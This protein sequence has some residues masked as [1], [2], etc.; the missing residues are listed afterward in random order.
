MSS[1]PKPPKPA[2][3]PGPKPAPGPAPEPTPGLRAEPLYPER[4]IRRAEEALRAGDL[5]GARAEVHKGRTHFPTHPF[6]NQLE[7][8]LKEEDPKVILAGAG[9]ERPWHLARIPRKAH[10]YWGNDRTSFLRYLSI[11]SFRR[12]NPD[13]EVNLYVPSSVHQG[14]S[15]W[16]DGEAY[17]GTSYHGRDYSALLYQLPG[18]RIREVDFS[19][20]PAIEAAPETYKSDFFRWHILTGEGGAYCDTD[21]LFCRPLR[22]APFNV[23][24]HRDLQAGVCIHEG[25]HI[26]GFYFSAP[27]TPLFERV[28]REAIAAFDASD[29]Q[30]IG[31][32][33]L[34]RLY[35][36]V[37][38]IRKAHP[39]MA[40]QSL[41]MEL[42]YPFDWRE[43]HR[44]HEPGDPAALPKGCI[45]IHWYAGST[46]TQKFNNLIDHATCGQ[47]GSLLD[48]LAASLVP[49]LD[50]K[51]EGG[52]GSASPKGPRFSV[53]VP[54]YNQAHFL[55]ATLDSL[56]GQTYGAWEALVVNDGST[57]G[58]R[59]VLEA[60]AAKDPRIRAFH[61]A[62]GGVGSALNA[63]LAQATGDWVGWLS[64]D[65]LYEPGALEAFA[66]AITELPKAR[67]FYSNFSQLFDETGEKRPMPERRQ[68][69]LPTFE[70][71]TL[72][73]LEANYVN[74]ITVCIQRS[75]LQESGG[76]RPE[77][78]YAQDL[79]LWLRLSVRTRFH[80]L[81]H[82]TA[83]T[84]VHGAQ[85]TQTFPMAGFFDSA[86][87]AH[88]FLN[89]HRFEAIF[90]WADLRSQAEIISVLNGAFKVACNLNAF[91]YHG[92]GP[93][94]VLL[95]RLDE[96]L[97]EKCPGEYREIIVAAL[98]RG[99]TTSPEL[100][101]FLR[102]RGARLGSAPRP[103]FHPK[104][105][106]AL[107]EEVLKRLEGSGEAQVS[108]E[109]R[110]YLVK[111][112]GRDLGGSQP[113]APAPSAPAARIVIVR[114]PGYA[115]ADA[116][117]EVAET[118]EAGLRALG[119]PVARVEN[120]VA[121]GAFNILLGWH[122]LAEEA[123]AALPEGTVLY[124]LEQM[125]ERNRE[126]R[127]RI[128]RLGRRHTVWD[129]SPRNAE[130]LREAGLAQEPG[131]LPIGYAPLLTRIPEAPREDIDV[132]FYGSINPRRLQILQDLQTA[133]LKVHQAFGVYGS[134]RDALI[135]RA[136]VVLNLHYYDSS[137]FELVR[138]SYLLANRKAVVAECHTATEVEAF[139]REGL[140]LAPY[141]GLVQACL[142][143]IADEPARRA[144]AQRGYERMADR[145]ITPLLRPLLPPELRPSRPAPEVSVILPTRD[146][147]EFLDRALQSLQAQTYRD[148]EVIVVK[149]GGADPGEVV[150]RHRARGLDITLLEHPRS[151]G[152]AA[153]RN[154]GIR[155]ARGRWIAYLDDDDL[156]YPDHLKVLVATLER[157]GAQ[158]A[159]TDSMRAVEELRDGAW[160]VLSR[161]LAMSNAF[162]RE[163][164]LRDNLTPVN[165]VLHA[166]ACWEA[167]G[168]H[169]ETLPV[170]EDWEF[171][172]RLSRRWDFVHVPQATAEVRWRSSGANITFEKRDLFPQCRARIAAKVARLLAEEAARR[173]DP[174]R[175]A[176]LF[177]PD[178]AGAGWVEVLLA[179]MEAFAPGDPVILVLPMDPGREGQI[180][181]EEA[182]VR[183]LD[184]VRRTG[185]EAFP[186]VALVDRPEELIEILREREVAQWVPVAGQEGGWA[187]EGPRGRALEAARRRLRGGARPEAP[188]FDPG[189]PA[190]SVIIPTRDRPDPL[191][192]ALRSIQEQTF[193]DVEVIVVNDG[194]SPVEA[195]VR[196]FQEA[197][198]AASAL[199][200]PFQKGQAAARNSG[201]ARAKGR[202][203]AY[204][205]DDDRFE[206][207][208]LES[209]V[210]ALRG[211]G[212][213]VAYSDVL[214]VDEDARG[215]T[216][217]QEAA[218][219]LDFDRERLLRENLAPLDAVLHA[220]AC[221]EAVGPMDEEL[222]L[223]E[224]W[225]FLI[226]LSRAWDFVHVPKAT[227]Q[228]RWRADGSNASLRR[229]P[230]L[231][232]CRARI[233]QKVEEGMASTGA[234]ISGGS[235]SW[236]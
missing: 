4:L 86:R 149:D 163:H 50:V 27:G 110:R 98:R 147:A 31:S 64:S 59:E 191:R 143:A 52:H 144:V 121:P 165:N 170:L 103:P 21:I 13:W 35:P 80:Y 47:V 209:L 148:F 129:Y 228:T 185:R 48:R 136:K 198:L 162:D 40:V 24:K 230:L 41:P 82:R 167:V 78:R 122:L 233:A 114:P 95:D 28:K 102:E 106:I 141:E 171:W 175:E 214:R 37:E 164:F 75:L 220:R 226:R 127:E 62:N 91:L 10:F 15:A 181:L 225:D 160:V 107:M 51:P 105:P 65:D 150:A 218:P 42:V 119:I 88:E 61:Q 68:V 56:R 221:L 182:Q 18:I 210:E 195:I 140:F 176:F 131:M 222:P 236:T 58:T 87:A 32:H 49:A 229:A 115:H 139:L 67:Y 206:P 113:P 172:I 55:P 180:G 192:R 72:G 71:Q 29:Y 145:S 93:N 43:I 151:W 66:G 178:W 186:D 204:L 100:P 53:L 11:A 130:I 116:F 17:E 179:Y 168:P 199:G 77:L 132:L 2:K 96:W 34:N 174:V 5:Q 212:A 85:G 138:V 54:T 173:A 101:A 190:V 39:G 232:L 166:R 159:Y 142:D 46:L 169:D 188:A 7:A 123:A 6:F 89:T 177:E 154:T 235:I 108:A 128:V 117:V 211:S 137:I 63:A 76:W 157:T 183:V 158:V 213:Q 9:W 208:H 194:G 112:V 60:Y 184:L 30:S 120:E 124:N 3:P 26:I 109:L 224:D 217:F 83:V 196:E 92:V 70:M 202:W 134:E 74:G 219:S 203:I 231:A 234:R 187:L 197:G 45:G 207:G 153:S 81:D 38:S 97:E 111:V 193:R 223:L 44:I 216:L 8:F 152:Q 90:P 16:M 20:Y 201:L 1:H 57:D 19:A 22:S 161:E 33:L 99:F 84:R 135:A 227:V 205:D 23:E 155:A 156:Y 73:L 104:D 94:T 14:A 79:D 118:L 69:D 189:H 36:T 25:K 200:H 125:D 215:Q 133:G 146:R 12:F 126:L